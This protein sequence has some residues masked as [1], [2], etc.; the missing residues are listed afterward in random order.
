MCW[1]KKKKG[2]MSFRGSGCI[3]NSAPLGSEGEKR[4]IKATGVKERCRSKEFIAILG[5]TA[6]KYNQGCPEGRWEGSVCGAGN[7]EWEIILPKPRL[8]KN[9][10]STSALGRGQEEE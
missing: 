3:G 10:F 6:E 2:K 8:P 5:C 7:N 1:G 4:G 9:G